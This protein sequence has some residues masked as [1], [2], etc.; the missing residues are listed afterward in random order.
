MD[1]PTPTSAHG[2]LRAEVQVPSAGR[3]EAAL[4]G[5]QDPLVREQLARKLPALRR[6]LGR[7]EEHRALLELCEELD[8]LDAGDRLALVANLDYLLERL[9]VDALRRWIITGM[10]ACEEQPERLTRYLRLEDELARASLAFEASGNGLETFR[11]PLQFYANGLAG[12]PLDLKNRRNAVLNGPPLRAVITANSLLLPEGYSIVDGTDHF[13]LYCAAVAHAV[14]H[15]RFSPMH[16]DAGSLKPMSI[17]IISLIEDARVEYLLALDHPGLRRLWGRFHAPA[18]NETALT[19]RALTRR[20][21]CALHDGRVED[22][23]YWVNKG[24][25]LFRER[26]ADPYDYRAFREIGSILANDLGQM[27]V[28]FNPQQYVPEPAYCD[29]NSF[30]WNFGEP[31]PPP[32]QQE[33]LFVQGV[34]V[35]RVEREDGGGEGGAGTLVEVEQRFS[36]PEWEY[37]TQ[38]ERQDWVTLIEKP[39]QLGGSPRIE[40]T[41]PRHRVRQSIFS[42]IKANQLSRSAKLRRQWEGDQLD[43][44][45]TIAALVD[46]RSGVQPDP[47][48]FTKPGRHAPKP[49]VLVLLDLSES[50]NDR[51]PGRYDSVLDVAKGATIVLCEAIG[52]AAERFAVHGFSSNGR[53]EVEYFRVKDFDEPFGEAQAQRVLALRGEHSTRIGAAL[54]HACGL[55]SEQPGDHKVVLVVTDGE[56][57]DVDVFDRD[58]LIEDA[59]MAV[60]VLRGRGVISFCLTLDPKAKG[61]VSRIFGNDFLIVDELVELPFHLSKAFVK[62]LNR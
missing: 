58:Y 62:F 20:L 48:V 17:A 50:T 56:P 54:R 61:Y 14:A 37:R 46:Y 30:L 12:R 41:I 26:L 7:A 5:I 57:S 11:A 40:V 9:S 44:N 52:E 47:R 43:L 60:R 55:V 42:L 33:Q 15:L 22:E 59:A 8:E 49:S 45:G 21:A 6:H 18:R 10:R 13:R 34:R 53:H 35:E 25:Q 28:R 23:N 24:V 1:T 32:Q 16:Q 36:Y 39:V 31:Q 51:I 2:S 3:E 19:F 38:T 4:E 27:R 29:D